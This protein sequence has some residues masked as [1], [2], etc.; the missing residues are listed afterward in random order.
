MRRLLI[1][2]TT[3]CMLAIPAPA[4]TAH[5]FAQNPVRT[6]PGGITFNFQDADI[7]YV[8]SMLAQAAGLKYAY[9][10]MPQ[11]PV[12]MRT[13]EP[14]S[15]EA[16]VALIK[17]I[18]ESNGIVVTND[19]GFLRLQ[20]VPSIPGQQPDPRQLYIVRLKHARAPVL[21]NTLSALFGG[22]LG[23]NTGRPNNATTLTGQLQ[24]LQRGGATQQSITIPNFTIRGGSDVTALIIPDELTNSLLI[25]ATPTDWQV[26]QQAVA[27]LDL[28]PLQVVIEVIIAEVQHSKDL[29]IGL[30]ANGTRDNTK[31]GDVS[32]GL[33]SDTSSTFN[34]HIIHQ[35]T[36][37][38]SATLSAFAAKGNVRIL[39]RPVIQAQNNQEAS[40]NVGSEVPFVQAS[41]A[42]SQTGALNQ[43]IQYRDVGTNLTITPTI[44]PDGY[45][46]MAVSQ[47]VSNATNEV[48]FNA[49]VIN[50]REAVTQILAK[51]GQTVAIGGLIDHT[52]SKRRG[53][54]PFLKDIP[55]IGWLFGSTTES[56]ANSELFLFL[57]PHVVMSDEDADR[58]KSEIEKNSSLLDPL[59]PITPFITPRGSMIRPDTSVKVIKTIKPDSIKSIKPDSITT[60]KPDSIK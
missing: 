45:V 46:N 2:A 13:T 58:M 60:I 5:A 50:T 36:I 57:T 54:I 16:V 18:A 15:P 44:N 49:P 10:D 11:K 21:A 27:T 59:L 25:R 31:I 8:V 41:Q 22:A 35:G 28:R 51:D 6:T 14:V 30:S 7:S 9:S 40:I 52:V 23:T 43:I 1:A 55:L 29:N 33:K 32:G 19:N 53:G 56:D 38:V 34:L 26:I 42:L 24:N 3:L 4:F 47:T 20:G 48:Q 12:T 39:A 37:D 17:S